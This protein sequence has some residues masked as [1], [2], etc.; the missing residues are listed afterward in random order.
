MAS[1]SLMNLP[2]A[3]LVAVDPDEDGV[4]VLFGHEG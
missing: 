4:E 1:T 3:A 2:A